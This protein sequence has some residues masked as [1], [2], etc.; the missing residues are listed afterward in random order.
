VGES[1]TNK[2]TGV[3]RLSHA[4]R[5]GRRADGIESPARRHTPR[6]PIARVKPRREERLRTILRRE[7]RL[8]TILRRE[9]RLRT[10]L[11]R[12]ERLR[13]IL[14]ESVISID[15]G[16]LP[17]GDAYPVHKA[18]EEHDCKEHQRHDR[19]RRDP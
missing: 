13:T 12:E 19:L 7:E 14:M 17:L 5:S 8:R 18:S 15:G 3:Q 10:I 16:L 2:L 9:E 11:R 1:T 4:T 6:Q